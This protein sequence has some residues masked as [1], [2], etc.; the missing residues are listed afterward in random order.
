VELSELT[1]DER[2]GLAALVWTEVLSNG[3]V[4]EDE[5]NELEKLVQAWGQEEYRKLMDEGAKRFADLEQLK[6]YLGTITRPDARELIFGF[7]Y[8]TSLCDSIDLEEAMLLDWLGEAW[9]V[10]VK[11]DP[12]PQDLGP[13]T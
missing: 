7:A 13:G 8:E 12:I 10:Q 5:A 3:E 9:N 11:I 1:H 2:L 4:S 6:V